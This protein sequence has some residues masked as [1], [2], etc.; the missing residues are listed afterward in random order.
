MV[1]A[2]ANVFSNMPSTSDGLSQLVE[3]TL[4][5]ITLIHGSSEPEVKLQHPR[6]ILV[7]E[8][9]FVDIRLR[10]VEVIWVQREPRRLGVDHV[11]LAV[12][13]VRV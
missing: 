3:C 5:N 6:K 9:L 11:V 8:L 12:R 2:A 10:L 4:K 7:Q 1:A 13:R